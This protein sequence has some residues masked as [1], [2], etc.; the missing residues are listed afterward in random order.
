MGIQRV[1]STLRRCVVVALVAMVAACRGG[2]GGAAATSTQERPHLRIAFSRIE[3]DDIALVREQA[4]RFAAA[5]P[6]VDVE[7]VAQKW[8]T[9]DVHD[10]WARFL[11]LGDPSIDVYVI[12]EPWIAEFAFAGWIRPIDELRPWA[13]QELHPAALRSAVWHDHLYAVPLELS[14]NALFYRRDLL[15]AAGLAPPR[16]LE[17]LLDAARVLQ[18]QPD[19]ELL[20]GLLLHVQ[21]LHNDLYPLLW[22]SGGGPLTDG[23][24]TLD[25]PVN[26]EVLERLVAATHDGALPSD[27]RLKAWSD[28][29]AEYHTAIEEFTGG[30]AAFMINWLRYDVGPMRDQV[31]IAPIPGLAGKPP[32]TGATLGSWSWA[33]NAAS[34]QP[35]LAEELIRFLSSDDASAERLDKLGTFPPLRRFYDDPA[36]RQAHPELEVAGRIFDGARPRMP[37]P[38][39]R[40]IDELIEDDLRAVLLGGSPVAETLRHAAGEV[41]ARLDRFPDQALVLPELPEPTRASVR[42]RGRVVVV[43]ASG[44]WLVAIVLLV[45]GTLAARRRGGLFHRLATKVSVLGLATILLALTTGTAVALA[46][47]VQNQE[48]AI[49]EAQAIFRASIREHSQSLGRQIAL[50]ASVVR[51][52][53]T[54]AGRAVIDDEVQAGIQVAL[55]RGEAPS[56]SL[57][58]DVAHLKRPLLDGLER[59]YDE[60]LRVLAA[61]GSYNDD[62]LF[63]QLLDEDGTIVADETDFLTGGVDPDAPPRVV[64]DPG[65]RQVAQFGRRMSMRDVPAAPGRPAYLEVMVPLVQNGRHAG[66]VRI[67]YSKARQDHRIAAL[68]A[69]QEQLLSRAV[70]LVL[71]AAIGL[72]ALSTVLL[73]LFSRSVALPLVRLSQLAA[74]VGGGDLSVHC[75]V[76]GRDEVA[77]LGVRLNEMVDGLRER[78]QIRETL[79]RYVGPT[80]SDAIL[81]G[82]VELGGEEREVTLLFSD[83]RGFTTMSETMSPPEVVKVLNTYFEQ[84]V[85]AV[86]SHDGML[87]KF[88]GDGLMAVF[89]APRAL[90]D[91]AM[92]A[93]RCALEMRRRLEAVNDQLRAAGLPPLAIGIGLHTGSVVVGNIGSTKR[94]EYTAIGDTVNLAS[95]LEGLTKERGVDI[96]ISEAT[97]A[98]IAERVD[99]EPLGDA[100][101]K[102]KQRAVT[103]YALRALR[104]RDVA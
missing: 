91:H 100:Q 74:R 54:G 43:A 72:V 96:L 76:R 104:V 37:V 39:E 53:S 31:G 8:R 41:R 62:I 78:Q 4:A 98:R 18:Q 23:K 13:D 2:G 16:T 7:V 67:G 34:R 25:D 52:L 64:D 94:T 97:H 50:G 3:G 44:V 26:V 65:V 92:S 21:F 49:G 47:L 56:G 93:A 60:S 29:P 35:A 101:V 102:G 22:A 95:R 55:D 61:E 71:V 32:G 84:M 86:F 59:T 42:D 70:L 51:E 85:E 80:V 89:G 33:V 1:R 45:V 19:T 68:R 77:A 63:L 20:Y 82:Q 73:V 15:D 103:I 14:A 83:V 99:A 46:V 17:E 9:T 38:N 90:D 12:D 75:D 79:G 30:H 66:A 40:E 11:A 69:R 58:D 6:E 36:R 87:D 57:R 5:H 88:I 48:E 27:E 10:L 81:G 24:V 28:V